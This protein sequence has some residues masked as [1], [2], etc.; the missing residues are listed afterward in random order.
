MIEG[1][2]PTGPQGD[3]TTGEYL[4]FFS[5]IEGST[6]Q[7]PG[8]D[9]P[10]AAMMAEIGTANGFNGTG[11]FAPESYDAA[12]LIMLAMQAAGSSD[13]ADYAGRVMVTNLLDRDSREGIDAFIA[14][15]PPVWSPLD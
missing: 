5:D 4:L 6:G 7:V 2:L 15:R 8:T 12:A 13:P 9:S 11:P 1:E 10:G 14:K 3:T